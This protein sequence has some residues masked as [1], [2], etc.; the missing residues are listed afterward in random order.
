MRYGKL[1][2]ATFSLVTWASASHAQIVGGSALLSN[3]DLATLSGY[4]GEGPLQLTNIFTKTANDGQTSANFHTAVD[5]KGRTFNVIQVLSGIGFTQTQIIG[6]Y[7]PQSWDTTSNYHLVPNDADKTAFLFNL[8]S[9]VKQNENLDGAGTGSFQTY[10]SSFG[11]T[12][13][14]G[15]DI[16]VPGDLSTGGYTFNYSYGGTQQTNILGNAGGSYYS[17][18]LVYGQIEVFTIGPAAVPEPG[19]IALLAGLSLSGAAFLRHR[20]NARKAL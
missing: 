19:S 9:G 6:G 8:T 7:D 15:F 20:K 12:F 14:G 10:N 13:G 2:L 3:A 11:P 5:G 16:Y 18:G 17:Q 4:L 1:A